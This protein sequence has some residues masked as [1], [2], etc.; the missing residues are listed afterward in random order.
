VSKLLIHASAGAEDRERASLPWI[1]GTK[2]LLAGQEVAIMLTLDAVRLV[3][4]GGAEG[5]VHPPH[6]PVADLLREFVDGG[7]QVWACESCTKPRGITEVVEGAEIRGALTVVEFL[8][9]GA[10]SIS[11]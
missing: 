6:P 11:F 1:F 3:T 4:E 5:V 9:S 10:S 8:A 2:A 7:G